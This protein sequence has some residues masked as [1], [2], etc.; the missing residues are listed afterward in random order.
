MAM[1]FRQSEI[2]TRLKDNF[3]MSILLW[4]LKSIFYVIL[5]LIYN[6]LKA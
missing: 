1:H 5:L 2:T 4:F 6:D 3:I